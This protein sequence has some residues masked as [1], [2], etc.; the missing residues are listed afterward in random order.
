MPRKRLPMPCP[1]QCCKTAAGECGSPLYCV[2]ARL[3][4]TR[5]GSRNVLR[6]VSQVPSPTWRVSEA[7][8]LLPGVAIEGCAMRPL[9]RV[10][11]CGEADGQGPNVPGHWRY[12]D[13]VD[14]EAPHATVRPS[15]FTWCHFDFCGW[16]L[17]Q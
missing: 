7:Y 3:N 11:S 1:S 15:S 9:V 13:L 6:E 8:E 4:P 5:F 16:R 10:P 17:P 12:K 2:V 14:F